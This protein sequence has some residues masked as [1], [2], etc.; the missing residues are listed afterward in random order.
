MT[1]ASTRTLYSPSPL[2]PDYLLCL[3][4]GTGWY[5]PDSPLVTSGGWTITPRDLEGRDVILSNL[6][7]AEIFALCNEEDPLP[8]ILRRRAATLPA[9][10]PYCAER[11]AEAEA[12]AKAAE[13]K[14]AQLENEIARLRDRLA[15]AL[16]AA[17]N[18]RWDLEV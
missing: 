16:T 6:S 17:A 8:E 4:D 1:L 9:F 3:A 7:D 15:E 5:V 2:S 10:G 18:A 11:A 13:A 14:V 12:R